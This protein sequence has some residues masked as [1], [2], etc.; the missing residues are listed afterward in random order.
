MSGSCII[1]LF[2]RHKLAGIR[3]RAFVGVWGFPCD[4]RYAVRPYAACDGGKSP[5]SVCVAFAVCIALYSTRGWFGIAT[6]NDRQVKNWFPVGMSVDDAFTTLESHGFNPARVQYG[7]ELQV[8]GSKEID[9]CWFWEDFMHV[10]VHIDDK[11][12]VWQT[13]TDISRMS[14]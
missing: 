14:L 8:Q 10:T 6:L 4:R 1:E 3:S 5:V 9:G 2:R 11:G 7:N 12:R 13:D